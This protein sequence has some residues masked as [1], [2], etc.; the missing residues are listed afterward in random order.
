MAAAD[1]SFGLAPSS[2]R[3]RTG[4]SA[5]RGANIPVCRLGRTEAVRVPPTRCTPLFGTLAVLLLAGCAHD[6]ATIEK[7]LMSDRDPAT[8]NVKVADQYRVG[9]PDEVEIRV[10]SRSELTGRFPI[11]L[12]GTIEL[13]LA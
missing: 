4:M 2:G 12:D 9:C 7:N 13:G 5:P 10:A 11:D 1:A 3:P 6:R 8:R